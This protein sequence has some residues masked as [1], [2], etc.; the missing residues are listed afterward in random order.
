MTEGRHPLSSEHLPPFITGPGETDMLMVGTG[1]FLLVFALLFG[2]LYLRLHC[3]PEH[4]VDRSKKVQFELV[5]VLGL[6]AMFTHIHLFW[7]A[8]LLLA[9]VDLPDLAG[10]FDRIT[11]SLEKIS[12]AKQRTRSGEQQAS[13]DCKP[14]LH[15]LSCNKRD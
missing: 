7:V 2:V 14:R 8:A 6:L 9:F 11:G 1:I 5:A 10:F 3:L 15:Q 4:I 13:P 12:G